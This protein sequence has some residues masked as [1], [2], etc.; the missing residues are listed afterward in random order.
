MTESEQIRKYGWKPDLPS[1]ERNY[2]MTAHPSIIAQFPKFKFLENL[3]AVYDQGRL[4]SCTANA[5][6]TAFEYIQ[7]QQR[8]R[9]FTPSRLFIYYNERDL[10]G[11][12]PVDS[13]ATISSGIKCL[14]DLGVC[15]ET[16][17]PYDIERFTEKPSDEAYREASDHQV[18]A[19]KRVP[20]SVNGFKTMINMGYPVVFGF[21][22][23]PYLESAEM[24]RT[25]I[26]KMPELREKPLGGHAVVCIGYSDIMQ[27]E[28]GLTQ[29]Y[30]KI[31]NSWGDWGQDGDFWMPYSYLTLCDDAW[32]ITKNEGEMVKLNKQLSEK[33]E[34]KNSN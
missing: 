11:T 17:W 30:L 34:L 24:A 7:I 21:T 31:R 2:L 8:L 3:P 20:V 23:F 1:N 6:G 10:E 32:V 5:L 18:L 25:G 27:S 29:G 9:I 15:A 26:L 4:G 33:F 13:G 14:A 12:I 19:S 16:V 28:D 22:V